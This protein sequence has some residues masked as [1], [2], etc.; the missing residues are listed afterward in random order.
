MEDTFTPLTKENSM[1][2]KLTALMLAVTLTAG[3]L[4]GCSAAWWQNLVHNPVA[5]VQAF[6]QSVQ[7]ILNIA[8]AAWSTITM[9]LPT[10]TL[11]QAQ[12][13]Y[14][15]AIIAAN[16]ALTTLN[17]AAQAAAALQGP[18]PDFTSLM[19]AVSDAI[20]QVATV[21]AQFRSQVPAT[22]G[23]AVSADGILEMTRAITVMHHI[24]GV[25]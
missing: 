13:L 15:K 1:K 16:A 10:A 18:M 17:D 21:V 23:A 19:Q 11:A 7:N 2:K 20:T 4:T 8:E 22:A 3:T 25:K 5:T 12:P 24:G 14:N 6:E 9:F